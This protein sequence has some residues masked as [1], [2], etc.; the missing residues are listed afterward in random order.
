MLTN[1]N[2]ETDVLILK[3]ILPNVISF[4]NVEYLEYLHATDDFHWHRYVADTKN[5]PVTIES[6][7]NS[8]KTTITWEIKKPVFGGKYVIRWE[9]IATA[10]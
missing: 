2:V 9:P 3:V 8:N 10:I 7:T 6:S 1:I 4:Q 5:S